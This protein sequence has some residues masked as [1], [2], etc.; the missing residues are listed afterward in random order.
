M[1]DD[2]PEDVSELSCFS[3]LSASNLCMASEVIQDEIIDSTT[4]LKYYCKDRLVI[5]RPFLNYA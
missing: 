1:V 3:S 4:R 2:S 5:M